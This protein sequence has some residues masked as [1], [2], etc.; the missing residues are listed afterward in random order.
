M[1]HAGNMLIQQEE[2]VRQL[3]TKCWTLTMMNKFEIYRESD[4]I[5]LRHNEFP[6]FVGQITFGELSDIE[7][8]E[9]VDECTDAAVWA[10]T[11]REAGE[12]IANYME[13]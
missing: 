11:M 2:L 8:I 4:K 5:M 6:R 12:F 13:K 7:N 3:L 1:C 10:K 9:C